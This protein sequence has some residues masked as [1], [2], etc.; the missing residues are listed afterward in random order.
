MASRGKHK[1]PDSSGPAAAA[2]G[3]DHLATLPPEQL[4]PGMPAEMFTAP[5]M[6]AIADLLPVMCAYVDRN[7]TYRF[8]NRGLAEWFDKPRHEILGKT[9]RDILGDPAWEHRQ[10]ILEAALAGERQLFVSDIDHETRGPCAVQVQYVPWTG[11]GGRVEGLVVLI[12][13]VTEQRVTELALKESEA[14]FKRIANS[15]PV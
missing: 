10:P 3:I 1:Q 5:G 9:M 7:F 13:D 6:L 12:D 11:P 15:A 2:P 8:L 4:P 14:R